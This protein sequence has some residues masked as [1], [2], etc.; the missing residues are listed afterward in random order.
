[1]LRNSYNNEPNF[2]D[3]DVNAPEVDVL[4]IPTPI[5]IIISIL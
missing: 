1:M 2:V 4:D 5:C 3:I